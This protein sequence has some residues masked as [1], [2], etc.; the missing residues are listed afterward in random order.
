MAP[1]PRAYHWRVSAPD[2][3]EL[4]LERMNRLQEPE[5]LHIIGERDLSSGTRT[6]LMVGGA[7]LEPATPAL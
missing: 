6:S 7:G 3:P 1:R 2:Q 5:A 4:S